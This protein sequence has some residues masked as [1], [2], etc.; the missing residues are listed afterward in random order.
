[1]QYFTSL[2]QL[3]KFSLRKNSCPKMTDQCC[4]PP[5]TIGP[6][7]IAK[8]RVSPSGHTVLE[9]LMPIPEG[10]EDDID[11]GWKIVSSILESLIMDVKLPSDANQVYGLETNIVELSPDTLVDEDYVMDGT[12]C[13][14]QKVDWRKELLEIDVRLSDEYSAKLQQCL[15]ELQKEYE[16][17]L[18]EIREESDTSENEIMWAGKRKLKKLQDRLDEERSNDAELSFC[19]GMELYKTLELEQEIRELQTTNSE[20]QARRAELKAE[21][22]SLHKRTADLLENI[23][24]KDVEVKNKQGQMDD[25]RKDYKDLME[26][27]IA[28]DMKI[29]AYTKLPGESISQPGSGRGNLQP[30]RVQTSVTVTGGGGSGNIF[31]FGGSS[32]TSPS[33][34]GLQTKGKTGTHTVTSGCEE[35]DNSSGGHV[36][37][38]GSLANPGNASLGKISEVN[39]PHTLA[40]NGSELSASMEASPSPQVGRVDLNDSSE[41][42][43]QRLREFWGRG[44][45]QPGRAQTNAA[46]TP[47]YTETIPRNQSTQSLP[48]GMHPGRSSVLPERNNRNLLPVTTTMTSV[49]KT[50]TPTTQSR[51]TVPSLRSS[52]SPGRTSSSHEASTGSC[53]LSSSNPVPSAVHSS[54]VVTTCSAASH[55][56]SIQTSVSSPS[57][58]SVPVPSPYLSDVLTPQSQMVTILDGLINVVKG[59]ATKQESSPCHDVYHHSE[60]SDNNLAANRQLALAQIKAHTMAEKFDGRDASSYLRWRKA[61]ER[62]LRNINSGPEEWLEMLRLRTMGVAFGVVK[63]VEETAIENPQ[64]ALQIIWDHFDGR[65]KS[66]PKAA[67]NLLTK[68]QTFHPVSVSNVDKLWDFQLACQQAVVLMST[69]QGQQLNVLN[70]TDMQRTVVQCLDDVLREE[71]GDHLYETREDTSN[72]PFKKISEWITYQADRYSDPNINYTPRDLNRHGIPMNKIEASEISPG[73]TNPG[74]IRKRN[75]NRKS[76]KSN[77]KRPVNKRRAD[78]SPLDG[79]AP[80]ALRVEAPMF[81]PEVRKRGWIGDKNIENPKCFKTYVP[82]KVRRYRCGSGRDSEY[83]ERKMNTHKKFLHDETENHESSRALRNKI[84]NFSIEVQSK[85][86]F[87]ASQN[88]YPVCPVCAKIQGAAFGHK[89]VDRLREA[90]HEKVE[91]H[92]RDECDYTTDYK[93]ILDLPRETSHGKNKGPDF[94]TKPIICNQC[95]YTAYYTDTATSELMK[96]HVEAVHGRLEGHKLGD[97]PGGISVSKPLLKSGGRFPSH[98]VNRVEVELS[99]VCDWCVDLGIDTKN[100]CLKQCSRFVDSFGKEKSD[101]VWKKRLCYG[102]LSPNHVIRSCEERPRNCS[103]CRWRHSDLI[104]C[105]VSPPSCPFLPQPGSRSPQE[106]RCG[107]C[108][109]ICGSHRGLG[110]HMQNQHHISPHQM[111]GMFGKV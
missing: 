28:L 44:I 75:K 13:T 29:A 62:E 40:S 3:F 73:R 6:E 55:S 20:L 82:D 101:F 35:K 4:S 59:I 61:L 60:S 71:W 107:L 110:N 92:Q 18:A 83:S 102:C 104:P 21:N 32:F 5:V 19:S 47:L 39:N 37:H 54:P 58:G 38:G 66:T 14:K 53:P 91:D 64:E 74:A 46:D 106:F 15:W 81:W 43:R 80:K 1:M 86:F 33:G 98:S 85:G 52:L 76:K 94:S 70:Y 34:S 11:E 10:L 72:V 95:D 56:P 68:L 26:I 22:S 51:G 25:L 7:R 100:H 8:Y 89:L 108:Q 42:V 103:K 99:T 36:V 45:L 57:L 88:S 79:V 109:Y 97:V 84:E 30:G 63:S 9:P 31:G 12:D 65:Y 23:E 49:T 105:G 41:K 27:K 2:Y 67:S 78:D 90:V 77:H 69:P 48:P 93:E 24:N 87:E 17:R 111:E 16:K 50:T 96:I